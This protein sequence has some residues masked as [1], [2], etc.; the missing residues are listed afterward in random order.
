MAQKPGSRA[1][2]D[3]KGMRRIVRSEGGAE[4]DKDGCRAMNRV[5]ERD[6]SSGK[7]GRQLLGVKKKRVI[8]GE[9]SLWK[10]VQVTGQKKILKQV[11]IETI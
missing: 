10:K 6:G 7:V 1:L 5:T 3:G 11:L 8:S 4:E 2:G 9:G